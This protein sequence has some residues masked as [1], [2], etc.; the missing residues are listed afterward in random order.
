MPYR[1][2]SCLKAAVYDENGE[3][4]ATSLVRSPLKP[5]R[6]LL[7]VPGQT[8]LADGSDIL[9][10]YAKIVDEF[11]CIC[12][13]GEPSVHMTLEGDGQIVGGGSCLAGANPTRAEAG[14]AV[15]Y[16]RAGIGA[17]SIAL[18][19]E[20][21]GLEGDTLILHLAT[22]SVPAFPFTPSP[23]VPYPRSTAA[24]CPTVCCL[25]EKSP[26]GKSRALFSRTAFCWTIPPGSA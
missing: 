12:P 10:V 19:A 23:A 20:S 24:T 13:D 15:F 6:I 18:H 9:P 21:A 17:S 7:E 16:V 11:G 26:P 14:I 8:L 2:G 5:S 3:L 25:A 1:P 4:L 22:P